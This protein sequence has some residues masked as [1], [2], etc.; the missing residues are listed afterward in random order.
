METPKI[1]EDFLKRT[2]TKEPIPTTSAEVCVCTMYILS[3]L[4]NMA[5]VKLIR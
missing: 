3:I 5:I 1:S 2:M 4:T